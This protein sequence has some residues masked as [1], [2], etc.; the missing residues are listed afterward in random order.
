MAGMSKKSRVLKQAR[1]DLH[2]A[3]RPVMKVTN[4]GDVV[5]IVPYLLGFTP[6]ESLVIV[7]LEGPRR[8]FGPC[9]RL[10]LLED[11]QLWPQ[12]VDQVSALVTAHRFD[13][14]FLVAFSGCPEL[15]DPVVGRI[16]DRLGADGVRIVDAVRADGVRWWS[17]AC[18]DPS[19][20]ERQGTPY[21]V[22]SSRISA[23]AVLAGLQRAPDRDSLRAQ[24]EPAA[25]DDRAQVASAAAELIAARP[26]P[27]RGVS[28]IRPRSASRASSQVIAMLRQ[29]LCRPGGLSAAEV[30]G[31][32]LALRDIAAR[33]LAW[34]VMRRENA[35]RHFAFWLPVMRLLPDDLMP[36]AGG[37]TAFAAWLSGNGVLASHA[38]E[39]VLAVDP[40]YLPAL[41]ILDLLQQAIA[42]G[43][44]DDL[45]VRSAGADAA[46][47]VDGEMS[48][49]VPDEEVPDGVEAN[50]RPSH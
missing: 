30:A 21:D 8:R 9:F 17:Y 42:P 12:L 19:C 22:E 3:G 15:A 28:P 13:A 7:S 20:C 25:S 43:A 47:G 34:G 35:Q 33:D 2:P 32:G 29:G 16:R 26:E 6:D 31:L 40:E 46:D 23:E 44:W 39:R 18:P 48:D 4:A 45:R 27:W 38:A 24:F 11:P 36:P 14:V 49:E 5:T 1:A 37:L 41:L 10:D 50:R